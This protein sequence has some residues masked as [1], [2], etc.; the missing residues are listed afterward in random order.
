MSC[1]RLNRTCLPERA[2][3]PPVLRGTCARTPHIITHKL[4]EI[5]GIDRVAGLRKRSPFVVEAE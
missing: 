4:R 1:A 5:T 2:P 3:G